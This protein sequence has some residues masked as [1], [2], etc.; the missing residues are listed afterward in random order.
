MWSSCLLA[1]SVWVPSRSY[2][3]HRLVFGKQVNRLPDV[4]RL[5]TCMSETLAWMDGW[6][7]GRMGIAAGPR[8]NPTRTHERATGVVRVSV[9]G[10][11]E[12]LLEGPEHHGTPITE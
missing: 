5:N 11:Q 12:V 10:K 4:E 8:G 3:S 2:S 9:A 6:T 7:D 1:V